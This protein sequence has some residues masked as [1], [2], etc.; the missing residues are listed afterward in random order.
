MKNG[1]VVISSLPKELQDDIDLLLMAKRT[2]KLIDCEL[3]NLLAS[4][5]ASEICKEITP[6]EA[7]WLRKKYIG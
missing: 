4:I 2:K 7:T 6:Q 5:N 1:E 3:S